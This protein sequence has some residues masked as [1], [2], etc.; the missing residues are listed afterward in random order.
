LVIK[1]NVVETIY[2]FG[3][4]VFWNQEVGTDGTIRNNKQD[5]V[6]RDNEKG[7]FMFID[8]G[9]TGENN[10]MD[11]ETE[12]TLK[13]ADLTIGYGACQPNQTKVIPAIIGGNWNHLRIIQKTPEQY[14]GKARN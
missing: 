2:E 10:V 6:I 11:K 1:T 4:T 8:I 3:V 13:Y 7:T 14:T 12:M 5:I 9:I